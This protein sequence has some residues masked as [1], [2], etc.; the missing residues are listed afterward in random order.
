MPWPQESCK[1][2]ASIKRNSPTSRA[3]S[4]FARSTLRIETNLCPFIDCTFATTESARF[5]VPR[6]TYRRFEEEGTAFSE[7]VGTR[8][9]SLRG[10]DQPQDLLVLVPV[11]E[12]WELLSALLSGHGTD[13][14]ERLVDSASA[15]SA[16]RPCGRP[17]VTPGSESTCPSAASERISFF[18]LQ[19]SP[20]SLVGP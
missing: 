17:R 6:V 16:S 4:F 13:A 3:S 20:S 19:H 14:R 10:V 12:S 2:A 1:R 7:T 9:E 11:D 5:K 8:T 15:Q 18:F